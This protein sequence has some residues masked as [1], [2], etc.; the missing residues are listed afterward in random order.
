[1]L[2]PLL[3]ALPRAQ[4]LEVRGD[5]PGA[6]PLDEPIG[7]EWASDPDRVGDRHGRARRRARR[8][9][10]D[11]QR[12][13]RP[14]SPPGSSPRTPPRPSASWT[15][16]AG[17]AG[18]LARADAVHGRLRADGLAGD[19]DQRRPCPRPARPGHVPRP[20]AA[21]VPRRRRREPDAVTVVVKLGSSL[22]V[23]P[24][25]RVRRSMLRDRGREIARIV[26]G[27]EPVCVVSSGAIA[28]GL[29]RLG[30]DRRPRSIAQLQAAS[31]LGQARL[32]AAWDAA[33]APLHGRAGAAHGR[34]RRRP[35]D[36]RQRPE[37]AGGAAQARRR[38]G[39]ERERR[40]RD[41]RDHLRRQRRARRPG[42]RAAPRASARAA[43]RGRG[44]L[45]AR[46]G[47]ARR[48]AARRR[49]ERAATPRSARRARSGAAG[50]GARCSP[51]SSPPRPGS[52]R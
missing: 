24:G 22:V 29:P 33:L 48:R 17:T 5:V 44:R 37:R 28:L 20:L 34:R 36:L 45:L 18:V 19:R 40:D 38:P 14:G 31:A 2:E 25:G 26:G 15:A 41:R 11:R 46:A 50:C 1:M 32:Q 30:L 13:R 27:G 16:T 23:G 42:R 9:A 35:H 52:R 7:H 6:E 12:R 21:P 39:R 49:G 8:G 3:D 10:A 51:P 43:H 47:H 4:G